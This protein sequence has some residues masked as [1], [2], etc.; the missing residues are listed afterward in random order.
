[1]RIGSEIGQIVDRADRYAGLPEGGD[2]LLARLIAY[3]I[4]D[5]RVE[6]IGDGEPGGARAVTL[7]GCDRRR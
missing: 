3:P 4:G 6:L 5:Q 7:P 2:D 1:M